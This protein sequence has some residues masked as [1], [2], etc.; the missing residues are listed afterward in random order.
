VKIIFIL[1]TFASIVLLYFATNKNNKVLILYIFWL[2]VIGI[3]SSSSFLQNTNANPPHFFLVM[4]PSVIIFVVSYLQLKNN[5]IDKRFLLAIHTLRIPVELMLYGLYLQKL[6]PK[7]MTYAGYNYD[8]VIGISATILLA[9]L[10]FT[11][12]QIPRLLLLIWNSIGILFLLNIVV[13]ALL[14]APLP[15]QQFGFEQPNIAIL[16]FP[17]TYLP[18]IIVPIVLIAHLLLFKNNK[19]NI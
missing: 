11:N 2:L 8:I 7:I 12:K 10:F 13:I 4:I 9:F 15:I 19:D 14:S 5:T 6:I 18:T 16:F 1:T 3:I 17:Y